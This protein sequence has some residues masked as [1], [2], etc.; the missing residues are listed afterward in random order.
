MTLNWYVDT[1]GSSHRLH[2]AAG[3]SD[4]VMASLAPPVE[5]IVPLGSMD[6]AA[7]AAALD[8]V[9]Q[10]LGAGR[11]TDEDARLHLTAGNANGT[12][13]FIVS[14]RSEEAVATRM[15]PWVPDREGVA[16]HAVSGSHLT[17]DV[18][19]LAGPVRLSI[20]ADDQW[21]ATLVLAGEHG[22]R[23]LRLLHDPLGSAPF[24]LVEGQTLVEGTVSQRELMGLLERAPA[25]EDITLAFVPGRILVRSSQGVLGALTTETE[26]TPHQ[27][28]FGADSLRTGLEALGEGNGQVRLSLFDES[29]H[30]TLRVDGITGR[31]RFALLAPGWRYQ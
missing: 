5:G 20:G 25:T 22:R 15:V 14:G 21:S 11:G 3:W 6:S 19:G 18:H 12:E 8:E 10:S 4:E 30:P 27:G 23:T 24:L 17:P 9:V 28:V 29:D 16:F 13:Y 2:T 7:L 26:G 1:D 31:S